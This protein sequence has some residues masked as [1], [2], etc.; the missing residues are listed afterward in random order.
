MMIPAFVVLSSLRSVDKLDKEYQFHQIDEESAMVPRPKRKTEGDVD[1]HS[2]PAD[3]VY[4]HLSDRDRDIVLE[5]LD[6][7]AEPNDAL[8]SLAQ[9]YRQRYG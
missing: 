4:I 5:M 8:K 9:R 2:D 1:S 7:E 6:A 3:Q